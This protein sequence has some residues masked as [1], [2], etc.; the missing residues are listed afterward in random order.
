MQTNWRWLTSLDQHLFY[1]ITCLVCFLLLL[2][3]LFI[4][5]WHAQPFYVASSMG[6][7]WYCTSSTH[8]HLNH[9]PLMKTCVRVFKKRLWPEPNMMWCVNDW[10]LLLAWKRYSNIFAG[11]WSKSTGHL[12]ILS[13]SGWWMKFILSRGNKC[14][15]CWFLNAAFQ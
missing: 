13:A 10:T 6:Y 15:L 9:N 11:E 14:C 8:K 5:I 3:C 12:N 1:Q 2:S 4:N 7:S